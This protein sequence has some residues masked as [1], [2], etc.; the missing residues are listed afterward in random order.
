MKEAARQAAEV[1]TSTKSGFVGIFIANFSAWWMNYGTV[2]VTAATGICGLIYTVL[3]IRIK[4]Q[5][6]RINKHQIQEIIDKEKRD[7][8]GKL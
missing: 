1:V 3:M 5:E 2:F 4:W 8:H 7:S 6:Y